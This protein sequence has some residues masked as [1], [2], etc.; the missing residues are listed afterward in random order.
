MDSNKYFRI[1]LALFTLCFLELWDALMDQ[2]D[3]NPVSKHNDILTGHH[4]TGNI[5]KIPGMNDLLL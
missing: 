1:R 2:E 5:R 4:K 3:D